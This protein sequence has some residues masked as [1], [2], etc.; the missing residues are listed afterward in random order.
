MVQFGYRSKSGWSVI[1]SS[2]YNY[3]ETAHT[4]PCHKWC[5]VQA[6]SLSDRTLIQ[7][8]AVA[9]GCLQTSACIPLLY[10]SIVDIWGLYLRL[11]SIF[12]CLLG[13]LGKL[14]GFIYRVY[15]GAWYQFL[16]H[17]CSHHKHCPDG[18][19]AGDATHQ[20]QTS[21]FSGFQTELI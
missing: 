10:W 15:H 7:R 6:I 18:T 21:M 11:S 1:F 3:W 5:K 19:P 17:Y 14:D 8:T 12:L 2:L 16:R 4:R 9:F 20:P 13:L